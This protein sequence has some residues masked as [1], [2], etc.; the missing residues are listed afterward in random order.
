M[1][2]SYARSNALAC[3]TPC[4]LNRKPDMAGLRHLQSVDYLPAR[5]PRDRSSEI[6]AVLID[7]GYR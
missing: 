7:R 6:P 3:T 2:M 4:L 1:A 5:V